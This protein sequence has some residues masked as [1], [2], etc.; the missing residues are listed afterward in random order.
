MWLSWCTENFKYRL[1]LFH[2]LTCLQD[3]ISFVNL[4]WSWRAKGKKFTKEHIIV[5]LCRYFHSLEKIDC[6]SS[7]SAYGYW[8]GVWHICVDTVICIDIS[9]YIWIFKKCAYLNMYM[10]NIVLFIYL[11]YYYRVS[12]STFRLK[13][14]CL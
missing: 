13:N 2:L 1:Q 7:T 6:G 10:Y 14:K 3:S 11:I 5:I 4:I 12:F 8:A 9:V